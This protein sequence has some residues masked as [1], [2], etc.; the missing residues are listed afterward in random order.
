MVADD[1]F[2]AGQTT[3]DLITVP[4]AGGKVDLFNSSAGQPGLT[5][6]I[7][8]YF[9]GKGAAVQRPAR[10]GISIRAAAS[11]GPS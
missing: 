11:A 1:S 5:A 7:A 10:R 3:S 9:S 8:G 2:S 4:I 6:D